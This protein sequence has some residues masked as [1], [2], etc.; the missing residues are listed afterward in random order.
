MSVR[1][2]AHFYSFK[3]WD[4][5]ERH[6]R[7]STQGTGVQEREHSNTMFNI[8]PQGSHLLSIL[9]R[10]NPTG[11]SKQVWTLPPSYKM[12]IWAK[13]QQSQEKCKIT[14]RI[15]GFGWGLGVQNMVVWGGSCSFKT[16]LESPLSIGCTILLRPSHTDRSKSKGLKLKWKKTLRNTLIIGISVCEAN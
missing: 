4:E 16:A 8:L 11:R 2:K 12:E 15:S 10:A 3:V 1:Q 6:I 5:Q 13:T 9:K 14:G 7:W